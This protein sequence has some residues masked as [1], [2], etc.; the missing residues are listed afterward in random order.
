[1]KESDVSALIAE[2][3]TAMAL[4]QAYG[5]EDLQQDR[6][7]LEN[8]E[9]LESGLAAMRLSKTFRRM[10]TVL[11]ALGTGGVVYFGGTL[12]LDKGLVKNK[13]YNFKVLNFVV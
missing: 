2:N 10:M 3:V 5:R 11:V 6:F 8:R 13:V 4:V 7:D 1:S 12:A 9:S